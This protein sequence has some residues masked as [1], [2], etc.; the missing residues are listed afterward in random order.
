[1]LTPDLVAT[2]GR[3]S[4]DP[5]ARY[6][7]AERGVDVDGELVARPPK[8]GRWFVYKLNGPLRL[9]HAETGIFVDGW[10]G[11][12]S[13]YNQYAS[14]SGQGGNVVVRLAAGP[15]AAPTSPAAC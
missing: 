8:T 7:L 4:P 9:A 10:M 14:P 2:D 11:A 13:A 12:E 6:V 5:G 3:L 15:G 1:M